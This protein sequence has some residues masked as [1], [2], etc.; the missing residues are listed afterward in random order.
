MKE[1]RERIEI[2]HSLKSIQKTVFN[3]PSLGAEFPTCY[4][5]CNTKGIFCSSCRK[6]LESP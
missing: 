4:T 5:D 1:A 3:Y 6:A 2:A